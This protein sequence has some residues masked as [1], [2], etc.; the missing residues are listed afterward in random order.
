MKL[1]GKCKSDFRKWYL[2]ECHDASIL[3][4]DFRDLHSSMQWGIYL[5]FL[6]N[7]EFEV[8]VERAVDDEL[9]FINTFEWVVLNTDT[10]DNY[11]GGGNSDSR[12]EAQNA[13]IEKANEIYNKA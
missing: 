4:N 12:A 8:I 11:G 7:V 6:D 2:N 5:D 1:T 9:D 3:Y 10:N 13:A